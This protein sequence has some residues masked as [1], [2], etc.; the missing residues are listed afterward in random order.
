MFPFESRNLVPFWGELWKQSCS[1]CGRAVLWRDLVQN[2]LLD[3]MIL[4][5]PANLSVREGEQAAAVSNRTM[6]QRLHKNGRQN[7]GKLG[8]DI[9]TQHILFI[10]GTEKIH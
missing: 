5:Y 6:K 3:A 4:R 10:V 2:V 9:L 8:P 1:I 7:V